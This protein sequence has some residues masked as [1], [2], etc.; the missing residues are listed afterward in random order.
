MYQNVI[1][2]VARPAEADLISGGPGGAARQPPT[3]GGHRGPRTTASPL[4]LLGYW[5]KDNVIQSR[6]DVKQSI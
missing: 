5:K 4:S 6:Y 3:R 2:L 1:A